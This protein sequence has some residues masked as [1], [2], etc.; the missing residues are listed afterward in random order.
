[1]GGS[2]GLQIA[3]EEDDKYVLVVKAVDVQSTFGLGSWSKKDFWRVD[4][5]T[6][7]VG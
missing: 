6:G 3:T 7:E 5:E 1:V 2:I 4:M